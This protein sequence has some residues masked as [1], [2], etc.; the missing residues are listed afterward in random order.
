MEKWKLFKSVKRN[1]KVKDKSQLMCCRCVLLGLQCWCVL[2]WHQSDINM[3]V[4]S[5][6]DRP[7][8]VWC[9]KCSLRLDLVALMFR[10]GKVL[11]LHDLDWGG[12]N[13]A[14]K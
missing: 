6:V 8:P 13:N 5:E 14:N 11:A 2:V 7:D 4:L 9:P 10:I 12:N 1:W 3:E